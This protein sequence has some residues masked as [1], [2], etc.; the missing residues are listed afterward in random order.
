MRF[1]AARVT[2]F[3]PVA[4]SVLIV[5]PLAA[6]ISVPE[7]AYDSAAN[8]LKLP[9]HIYLGEAAGVATNSKGHVF[10]YT[11][12]GSTNVS[13]GTSRTFSEDSFQASHSTTRRRTWRCVRLPRFL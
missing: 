5:S 10:V 7:I 12:T 11:R 1:L 2:R 6:Q 13:T 4:A 3:L 9:E 8:F